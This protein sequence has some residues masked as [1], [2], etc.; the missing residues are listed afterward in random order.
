M[1]RGCLSGGCGVFIFNMQQTLV[2]TD[3]YSG[4]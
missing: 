2:I 1:P 3:N 4:I